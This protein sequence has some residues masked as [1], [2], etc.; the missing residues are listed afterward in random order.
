M[1]TPSPISVTEKMARFGFCFSSLLIQAGAG[2]WWWFYLVYSVQYCS[3]LVTPAIM[4]IDSDMKAKL[5]EIR[6]LN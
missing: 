6:P 3:P 2:G 5:C 4:Q 1:T